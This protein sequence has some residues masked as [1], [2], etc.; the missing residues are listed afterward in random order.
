MG[1]SVK[2]RFRDRCKIY[3]EQLSKIPKRLYPFL[4]GFALLA[5]A[6][7]AFQLA[8]FFTVNSDFFAAEPENKSSPANEWRQPSNVKVVIRL[9]SLSEATNA[10]QIAVGA[11]VIGD[12]KDEILSGKRSIVVK[13]GFGMDEWGFGN[14][15]IVKI[16]KD[17]PMR[18]SFNDPLETDFV[19]GS[20][21]TFR[22]V[23]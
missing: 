20:V 10:I 16:D 2:A 19:S 9:V 12:L 3:G 11:T 13:V 6:F 7:T 22:D 4:T 14:V 18:R 23:Q 8:L 17:T 1:D 15:A 5:A 21:L